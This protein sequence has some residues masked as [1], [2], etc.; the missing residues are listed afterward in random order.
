VEVIVRVQES[1]PDPVCVKVLV[2]LLV[3]LLVCVGVCEKL[4][5]EVPEILELCVPV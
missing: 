2:A 4:Q 1:V 5:V 3:E